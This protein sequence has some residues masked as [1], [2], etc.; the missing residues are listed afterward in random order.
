VNASPDL[1][2]LQAKLRKRLGRARTRVTTAEA[3][4]AQ[5]KRRGAKNQLAAATR[6]LGSF[7][8]KLASPKARNVPAELRA[9]LTDAASALIAD[10]KGLRRSL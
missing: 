1:G 3:R 2:E 4:A 8:V 10:L 9:E 6:D 5:G 7:R